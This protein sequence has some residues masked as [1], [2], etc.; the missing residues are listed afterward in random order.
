MLIPLRF[1]RFCGFVV[2]VTITLINTDSKSYVLN[3]KTPTSPALPFQST[4]QGEAEERGKEINTS[5]G[6]LFFSRGMGIKHL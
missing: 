5:K 4:Y 2:V 3:P 1:Q 6:T